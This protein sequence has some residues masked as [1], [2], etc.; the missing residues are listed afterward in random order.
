MSLTSRTASWLLLFGL[1]LAALLRLPVLTAV[2]PGVH[3]DE[4]ANGI[5]AAEIGWQGERPLFIPSYTGKEVLFFYGAGLLAR[6]LGHGIFSL[7]LTAAFMGLLTVA[8][9]YWL[10]RVMQL[11]RRVALLAALLLA[12]SFWHLL[13][14]RL[15][16]RAISQPLMQALAVGFIWTALPPP[17]APVRWRRAVLA[18][19]CLGLVAYTYLAARL[20]PIALFIGLLPFLNPLMVRPWQRH[21]QVILALIGLVALVILAPLL[22]YFLAHPDAFW[23]RIS[24]V[25]PTDS[26]SLGMSY[27][28]S[29]GMFFFKGDPYWR[30]NL[31]DRPVFGIFWAPF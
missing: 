27:Q 28:R 5:L 2:P 24:Q 30:F 25:A 10:G 4:A 17:G 31:P 12:T 19:I 9:T 26:L 21:P 13:F 22:S 15:G 23:V 18:G 29:L 20:F 16:F 7:R 8:A 6:L 14:S 3:Y 11:D 1:L